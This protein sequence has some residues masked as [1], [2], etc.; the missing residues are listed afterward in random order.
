MTLLDSQKQQQITE[1][2][3]AKQRQF[4]NTIMQS[5]RRAI[6]SNRGDLHPLR[7]R[8]IAEAEVRL[9]RTFL[10]SLD[11]TIARERG[12]SLCQQGVGSKMLLAMQQTISEFLLKSLPDDLHDVL[13]SHLDVYHHN[14]TIAFVEAREKLVI[15]EQERLRQAL[16]RSLRHYTRQMNAA[17]DIAA[18]AI[19]MLD[20]NTLLTNAVLHIRVRFD[21]HFVGLYLVDS[22]SNGN[23]VLR[24]F[25]GES[26][27]EKGQLFPIVPQSLLG[28]SVL[29]R[30][31]RLI[32]HSTMEDGFFKA[33]MM[34]IQSEMAV[35]LKL[36]EVLG[37]L[38]LQSMR[39]GGLTTEHLPIFKTLADQLA[40]AIQNTLLYGAAQQE[41]AER[42]RAEEA[43]R[44]INEQ[45]T[46]QNY[47]LE[48]ANREL[49]QF[50]Y[51]A[52][53]DLKSP[54]RAISN[55]SEWIEEDLEEMMTGDTRHYMFLLRARVQRM[56][57]LIEGVL[58]YS[59]IGR[60]QVSQ[61]RVDVRVLL[62]QIVATFQVPEMFSIKI[63]DN[64]PVFRTERLRLEQV[65]ANLIGN[66]IKYHDRE[67]GC[68]KVQVTEQEVFYQFSVSDD[69]PGI[70][71]R[72]HEK[73]FVMFQ[74]L[75]PRDEVESTGVGLAIVKK[76]IDEQ[77]GRIWVDS[78]LGK[79]ATFVFTWPKA[80]LAKE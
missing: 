22:G 10:N 7:L 49:E 19:S 61:E 62:T 18:T 70:D 34:D 56:Q 27:W 39:V 44:Q 8:G 63:G 14:V 69:G 25:S 32:L 75:Q 20:L 59:Q 55:L 15:Q 16:E 24:A 48:A 67:D 45:L 38:H 68:V 80:V 23:L 29:N 33:P 21:F 42:K 50:A 17:S 46:R 66:A 36:D 60:S 12:A 4:V 51:I 28:W 78:S 71:S 35:P 57:S 1:V 52:S 31:Q 5:L 58:Q 54:L 3:Q 79:G 13:L 30:E 2:I 11:E 53:H 26:Q 43:L 6:F 64:M 37:V 74:T 41:I 72:F 76:I 40:I 77:G 47:E 65:F 73:I 9:V